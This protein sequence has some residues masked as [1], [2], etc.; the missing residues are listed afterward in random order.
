MKYW[1]H[2]ISHHEDIS[3]PLLERGILERGILTIGFS[4][5]SN[6]A[7]LDKAT[8][9]DNPEDLDSEI[10]KDYGKTRFYI[11]RFLRGMSIGDWVLVPGPKVFSVYEIEGEPKTISDLQL[12]NADVNM[13]HGKDVT[14]K[15]GLLAVDGKCID[16]GFY[17]E[18]AIHRI[19]DKEAKQISR[20]DYADNA[21]TVGMNKIRGT[22]GDISDLDKSF[23]NA[24]NA[25]SKGR[26]LKLY[27]HAIKALLDEIHRLLIS[28]KFELL[29]KWYFDRLGATTYIPSKNERDKKGDADIVAIFN[30]LRLTIYIQVKFHGKNSQTD[31]WAVKQITE[32]A[33]WAKEE[34]ATRND[35][36]HTIACWVVSTCEG[37]T[38]GCITKAKD[39]GVVLINGM[40]F[41][42][43]ML[44]AGLE[45]LEL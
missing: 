21:L 12:E 28:K 2:R 34:K 44:E 6:D 45:G 32:Y 25:W 10:K 5:L 36:E 42:R 19:G 27:P 40:E 30:D 31:D 38:D 18:V 7:F 3:R 43:M 39:S 11:W 17:R 16:L 37:F 9:A 8:S 1:L 29:V 33:Q 35:D 23:L 22:N 24:L 14:K 4:E 15:N 13:F 41:A 20:Y 26:P